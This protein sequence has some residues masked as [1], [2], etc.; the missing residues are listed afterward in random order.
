MLRY[1][2]LL[3]EGLGWDGNKKLTFFEAPGMIYPAGLFPIRVT[4]VDESQGESPN[5]YY[6]R[7]ANFEG[8][9]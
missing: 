3:Y 2:T 5:C 7:V 6:R 8:N 1:P 4:D 9:G